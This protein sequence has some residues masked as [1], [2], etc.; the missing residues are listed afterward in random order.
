VRALVAALDNAFPGERAGLE[1][2]VRE[3]V[4]SLAYG[5]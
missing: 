3:T 4:E 5:A 1:L 2:L